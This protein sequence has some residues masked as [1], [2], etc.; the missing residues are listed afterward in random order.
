MFTKPSD[1]YTLIDLKKIEIKIFNKKG[2]K[3]IHTE[4]GDSISN[5]KKNTEI[6]PQKVRNTLQ[7]RNPDLLH[8]LEKNKY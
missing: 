5:L 8:V 1:K 6:T 3:L 2:R 7:S 4:N